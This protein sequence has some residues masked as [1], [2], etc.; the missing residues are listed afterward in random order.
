MVWLKQGLLLQAPLPVAWGVSHAALPVA[1]AVGPGTEIY[2]SS[3]D[4]EGRS[5]IG[6][7]I[8]SGD[9]G[10]EPAF[11]AAP[12]LAPGDLG[13]F[14]DAGVTTACVVVEG[15]AINLYYS[16]WSLGQTVPFYFFVGCARSTD[17]GRT[18]ARV[19]TAPVLERNEVDP[20]LT[21]S[22]WILIEDGLWRMWYVSGTG[23]ELRHGAPRHRYHIKYAE[24]HDGITWIRGGHVCIDYRD[25][26]EYAIARPT[27]VR[28]HD[29]Y[30]MWYSSRGDAYRLGYA[31]SADG[32]TWVRD[33]EEAGLLPSTDG[34]DSEMICYPAIYD[35]DGRRYL[36]YNGNGFGA[37]GIGYAMV[38][39]S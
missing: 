15:D 33:D 26:D 35:R 28:D 20:Y 3:R 30:R 14:D 21:A 6:R 5:H 7:A 17:G 36:L 12:L 19:S 29:R 16:G 31:E 4:S 9:F 23:W 18:F 1:R 32:L 10:G 13:A 34:W 39:A 8:L 38:A 2:F 37:T 11:E 24:S 25:E 22:P 27:V